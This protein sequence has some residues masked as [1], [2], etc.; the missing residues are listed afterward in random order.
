[1]NMISVS[2]KTGIFWHHLFFSVII[3]GILEI[4]FFAIDGKLYYGNSQWHNDVKRAVAD[5][6]DI[7]DE[8]IDTDKSEIYQDR[9]I[10]RYVTIGW[11]C[12]EDETVYYDNYKRCEQ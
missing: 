4:V 11:S 3:S 2:I 5:E 8:Y 1:M 9:I 12:L 10:F 7:Y 6:K